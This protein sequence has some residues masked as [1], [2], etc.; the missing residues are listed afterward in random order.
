M[1]EVRFFL[2]AFFYFQARYRFVMSY[3]AGLRDN[4]DALAKADPL[5]AVC[6]DP[7]RTGRKWEEREFFLTGELEVDTVL[8]HLS[9][10]NI[11][12]DTRGGC[13]DFGCGV[14]RL[15]QAFARRFDHCCGVDISPEM[16]S[17][18]AAYNRYAGRCWYL[19][20][21]RPDLGIF[22]DDSQGFVYS[23]LVLQHMRP[24][25]GLRYLG[26]FGRILRPG[27]IAVVQVVE[28]ANLGALQRLKRFLRPRTR[29]KAVIE[30]VFLRTA[31][32]ECA[33]PMYCLPEA[34][35]RRAAKA[36]GLSVA[37]LAFTN[38]ARKDF[39]G[40]LQYYGSPPREGYVSRQYV[41]VK[42]S[43]G[44]KP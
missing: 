28:S 1:L 43:T 20:N 30:A 22:K 44:A 23:S 31:R 37:D 5:W 2:G 9:R 40:R 32:K 36:A 10:N 39:N 12:V 24:R 42:T 41:F 3:L 38:T 19:V 18:A 11:P 25:L 7:E 13:I 26:E 21:D 15:T 29:A 16:I 17:R 4:W 27:A 14:G 6:T 35:V 34:C 33:L 8:D